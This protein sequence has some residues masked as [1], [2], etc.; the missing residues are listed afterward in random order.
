VIEQIGLSMKEAPKR[1]RG[2]RDALMGRARHGVFMARTGGQERVWTLQT[3]ALE[4]MG[5]WLTRAAGLPVGARV[6]QPMERLVRDRLALQLAVPLANYDGL[7]AKTAARL[8]RDL[9]HLGLL[10]VRRHER[11]NK[12]RKTV[13]GAIE[14]QLERRAKIPA[15]V[16]A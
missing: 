10:R 7:N 4:G 5:S 2:K 13:L 3:Q 8:V 11:A 12:Q 15:K 9:D 14:A 1:I 6:S 16:P